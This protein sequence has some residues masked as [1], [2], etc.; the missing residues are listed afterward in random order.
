LNTMQFGPIKSALGEE[1]TYSDIRFAVA[2]YLASD[3]E[4]V[5]R[6]V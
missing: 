6:P 3:A 4:Q 1:Y 2:G 5:K